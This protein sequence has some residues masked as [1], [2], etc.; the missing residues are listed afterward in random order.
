MP[1]SDGLY[2]CSTSNFT[3]RPHCAVR[4]A[5]N[6]TQWHIGEVAGFTETAAGQEVASSHCFSGGVTAPLLQSRSLDAAHLLHSLSI[7]SFYA[8]SV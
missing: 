3:V 5:A 6:V 7:I 2:F 8:L 4:L 1:F